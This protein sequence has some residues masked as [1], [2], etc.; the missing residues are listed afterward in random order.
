MPPG[1]VALPALAAL[2]PLATALH[3]SQKAVEQ[4]KASQGSNNKLHQF[5]HSWNHLAESQTVPHWGQVRRASV[6]LG[7]LLFHRRRPM[8]PERELIQMGCSGPGGGSGIT[9]LPR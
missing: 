7:S 2:P 5:V 3:Q 1:G 9:L 6:P 4:A 8:A